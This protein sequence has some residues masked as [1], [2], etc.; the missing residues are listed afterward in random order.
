MAVYTHIAADEMAEF[1][2]R[3]D[4]GEIRCAAGIAQGVENSNYLI[5]TAIG[6][7]ILTLYER[8]VAKAD[9]PFF[10]DLLDHLA[11][12]GCRVPRFIP[13]RTGR[14]LQ[15]LRGRPA[16]V[17]QFLPGATVGEPTVDQCRSAGRALGEMHVA[18]ADFAGRRK[19]RLDL[20][21]WHVLAARCGARFDEVAPGLGWRVAGELA[22]LDAHW[23]DT[24]P[25]TVIH[26]DLFPD[27]V[28]V[29]EAEVTGLI[30]FYFSCRDFRAYDLAVAHAAWCFDDDGGTYHASRSAALIE[31]YQQAIR[32]TREERDAFVILCRGAALRFVL[33][34]AYDWLNTPRDALVTA[35]DP[36]A[37]KRRLEFYA[38][39]SSGELLGP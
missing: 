39:T 1:F 10:M 14:K 34:R 15:H 3:Y 22:F 4:V 12:R 36:L 16:C 2:A 23:P 26:A 37:F 17:V 35:K 20:S 24:L 9:L 21:A 5:E 11:A 29:Q 31:G 32:L 7:F 8:R 30:D 25:R 28:L 33:T 18:S 19:N 38:G 13:D 6:R 27:N